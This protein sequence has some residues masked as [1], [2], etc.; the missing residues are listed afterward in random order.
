MY[1]AYKWLRYQQAELKNYSRCDDFVPVKQE[2]SLVTW[3]K[4]L[5]SSSFNLIHKSR[6]N[7]QRNAWPCLILTFHHWKQA[8]TPQKLIT[9]SGH[10]LSQALAS[11]WMPQLNLMLLCTMLP[12][13]NQSKTL[14]WQSLLSFWH[15]VN[16]WLQG[17]VSSTTGLK[18][19]EHGS[20]S[21]LNATKDLD[22]SS[23]E[24][25]GPFN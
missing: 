15:V 3:D 22:I 6:L 16:W 2:E 1:A 10:I 13:L 5:E 20:P 18:V 12:R 4:L 19:S 7:L 25:L 21:F 24:E 8:L 17:S 23:S 9:N 14:L 11:V